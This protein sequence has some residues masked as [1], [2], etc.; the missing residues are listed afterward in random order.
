M[1][2]TKGTAH[3]YDFDTQSSCC[4][5][6]HKLK[7]ESTPS[8]FGLYSIRLFNNLISFG[9]MSLGWFIV[10]IKGQLIRASKFRFKPVPENLFCLETVKTLAKLPILWYFIW[11]FTVCQITSVFPVVKG[12]YKLL[13]N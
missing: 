8:V 11:V 10:E 1:N 4:G 5:T 12:S 7:D 6:C 9:T 13:N 3:C 2:S